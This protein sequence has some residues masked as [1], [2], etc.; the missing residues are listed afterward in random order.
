MPESYSTTKPEPKGLT[1]R[2]ILKTG[3]GFLGAAYTAGI[4]K[5]LGDGMESDEQAAA[6]IGFR[7]LRFSKRHPGRRYNVLVADNEGLELAYRSY[8]LGSYNTYGINEIPRLLLSIP[9]QERHEHISAEAIIQKGKELGRIYNIWLDKSKV[10]SDE[11]A[12]I[13]I[14]RMYNTNS[15]VTLSLTTGENPDN[16]KVFPDAAVL[17]AESNRR[18]FTKNAY[19]LA[20]QAVYAASNGQYDLAKILYDSIPNGQQIKEPLDSSL[21]SIQIIND[22]TPDAEGERLLTEMKQRYFRLAKVFKLT[23]VS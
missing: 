8:A 11:P 13:K 3:A 21:R 16:T 12:D 18:P 20:A 6:D 4:A 14:Q 7:I 23:D 19:I 17:V 15:S 22:K 10:L 2:E 5:L 9:E 1:R